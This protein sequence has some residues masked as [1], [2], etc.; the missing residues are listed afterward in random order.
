MQPADPLDPLWTLSRA[1]LEEVVSLLRD[2]TLYV[3]GATNMLDHPDLS[4]TATL[5]S[6][7]RAFEDKVRLVD[8]LSRMAEANSL[9]LSETAARNAKTPRLAP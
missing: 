8:L 1:V 6:M 3:S 2:R 5:R 4:D 7:L 9:P